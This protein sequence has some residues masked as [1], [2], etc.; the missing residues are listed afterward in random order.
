MSKFASKVVNAIRVGHR[1]AGRVVGASLK[2][3][4]ELL[5]LTQAEMARRLNV[6]QAAIS[7]IEH[8]GDVQISSL[9]KYVDALGAKLNITAVFPTKA[10]A[11]AHLT[12]GHLL[13]ALQRLGYPDHRGRADGAPV[14]RDR[15]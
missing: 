1:D 10:D 11:A 15:A 8:R 12:G 4:R 14:L 2:D 7:K 6:G 13:R 3:L 5:G 9:M